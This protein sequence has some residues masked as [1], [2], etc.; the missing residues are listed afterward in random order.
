MI[1]STI[2]PLEGK[3][4]EPKV[5]A[6]GSSEMKHTHTKIIEMY[7]LSCKKISYK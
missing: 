7:K 3:I 6:I 4:I 2:D 1:I 5:L